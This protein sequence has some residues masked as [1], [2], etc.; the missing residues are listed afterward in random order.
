MTPPC[1]VW[2]PADHRLLGEEGERTPYSV[3]DDQYVLAVRTCA[4]RRH[5]CFRWPRP[6]AS[7]NYYNW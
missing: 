1:L 7:P 5:W 6:S 2:L 3:L 4:G